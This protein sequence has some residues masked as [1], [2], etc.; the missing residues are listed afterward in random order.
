MILQWV[1]I[2]QFRHTTQTKDGFPRWKRNEKWNQRWLD[3]VW[4]L[5]SK[6]FWDFSAEKTQVT[7]RPGKVI[8]LHQSL[9]NRTSQSRHIVFIFKFSTIVAAIFAKRKQLCLET[10]LYLKMSLTKLNPFQNSICPNAGTHIFCLQLQ[11]HTDSFFFLKNKKQFCI[12]RGQTKWYN[13]LKVKRNYKISS[14]SKGL[15]N[16]LLPRDFYLPEMLQRE[17]LK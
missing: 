16:M 3:S 13:I 14:F 17:E 8:F 5:Y 4:K 9:F 15:S 2:D 11:R 6:S 7:Q 12:S 1:M 10:N